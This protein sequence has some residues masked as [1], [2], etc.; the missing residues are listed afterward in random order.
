MADSYTEITSRSWGGRIMDSIKGL[1]LGGLMVLV[2]FPTLWWNEGRAVK[3]ARSLEEGAGIVVSVAADAVVPGNDGK[4][5]HVSGLA[6]TEE[7]LQDPVFGIGANAIKLDRQVWAYQWQEHTRS[8]TRNKLGGGTETVTTYEYRKEWVD[9]PVSSNGFH[10][11]EGHRNP[12][13]MTYRDQLLSAQRVTVGAFRLSPGLVAQIN[14]FAPLP[15]TEQDLARLP[16][17]LRQKA[18]LWEGGYYLGRDPQTPEIGDSKVTFRVVNPTEV[19]AVARQG[20]RSLEP[21]ATQAG[22]TLE[23]LSLGSVSAPVMFQQA[24]SNNAVMTW[25]LRLVGFLVMFIG[26]F[27]LFRPLAVVA[28]VL[29]FLGDMLRMG[30]GLFAGVI[31]LSL[32]LVTIALAWL[33]Y[34]PLIS[35]PLL[36]VGVGAIVALKLRGRRSPVAA[37]ATAVPPPPPPA[38]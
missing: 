6:Q 17:D 35:I 27:V 31:A 37:P 12:G 33:T 18:H 14:K 34:R 38:A 20:G 36:L 5:V 28:D 2:A 19:S 13:T 3:T 30:L 24:L 22:R 11:P 16:V 10:H 23:M 29:P 32:S 25:V 7:R 4:L 26:L 9:R 1:L 21:Y 15:V 8:E